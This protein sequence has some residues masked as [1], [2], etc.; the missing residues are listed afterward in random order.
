MRDTHEDGTEFAL[1]FERRR[2]QENFVNIKS[3]VEIE[4][5]ARVVLQHLEADSVFSTDGFF[6][7]INADIE[8][9][10]EEII[11]V[12]ILAVRAT[13]SVG[14]SGN[15]RRI[16]PRGRGGLLGRSGG[17]GGRILLSL[18]S[19]LSGKRCSENRR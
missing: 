14:A 1:V 10:V 4:L 17:S 2:A 9:V 3:G 15:V 19:G 8:V 16:G 5:N 7:W 18:R 12:A 13:K 6:V 11:V